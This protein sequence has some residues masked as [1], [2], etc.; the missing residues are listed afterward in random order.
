MD[1]DAI[2]IGGGPAGATAALLLARGG[3]R[4]IVL[5]RSTFPRFHIGESLLPRNFPLIRELGLESRLRGLPHVPKFGVEFAMGDGRSS[6]RF[7]FDQ[8][9]LGGSETV[10]VERASFDA[11]LLGAARDAGAT[12]LEGTAV[13]KILCLDDGNVA[14]E[15]DGREIR[16]RWLL[17]AS[18]QATVVGRHLGT[19]RPCADQRLQKT[20]YFAH[21]EGVR[22][23]TGIEAGHPCIV[24]CEEG[25]F[26]LIPLDE[27]RT[28]VGLVLDAA[29]ARGLDVAAKRMLA[30]GIQ[31]C[32]AVLERMQDAVG[33]DDNL[34][35]ADF[36]YSCRP[37]AGRGYFLV[38]DAAAF[39]DPIF[40]TGVCL[41]MMA[42]QQAA[43]NVSG[44]IAGT[45]RPAAARKNYIR[46]VDGSTGVFFRLIRQYYDHSFRELF[47]N[48]SGPMR[49]H[50]AVLSIL[51]GHVF[52]R[53]PFALRWRL[54][55]FDLYVLL[56]RHV[57]LVP[58]RSRF[59]L[60]P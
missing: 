39:I 6:A 40:S 10:N 17:D 22:R 25:W 37:F 20:A 48:G 13:K 23:P 47:L 31:R 60:L 21:F 5:E 9:L 8:G 36:S 16:G 33:P 58:R 38:G 29:V 45:A 12:V 59:R 35:A 52:P 26:W 34:V 56:N 54:R 4:T 49:V 18:G 32:P 19:R 27:K 2:I 57:A 50:Q 3:A 43:I 11:M 46:Y 15:A 44:L 1:F 24:I 55:L 41:A 7:T 28:S 53:P 51:A 14:V 30:W 42:A